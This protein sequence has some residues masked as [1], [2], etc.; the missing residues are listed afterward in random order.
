MP[1][2]YRWRQTTAPMLRRWS[3]RFDNT[4]A[5]LST[6][7]SLIAMAGLSLLPVLPAY[8]IAPAPLAGPV[9]RPTETEGGQ[10][11]LVKARR[12]K[13]TEERPSKPA[14]A[15]AP[16]A[17]LPGSQGEP[18]VTLP[19]QETVHETQT[20][21]KPADPRSAPLPPSQAP[22]APTLDTWSTAEINE[23][24]IECSRLL[25]GIAAERD[26]LPPMRSGACGTPAPIA[27]RSVGKTTLSPAA[28]VNCRLA[29]AISEWAD[30][31]LQPA[32]RKAFG[33]PVTRILTASSYACRNR[34]GLANTQISEHA[35]ANAV[36]ITGFELA[37]GRTVTVLDA[38]GSTSRDSN[39]RDASRPPKPADGKETASGSPNGST[40]AAGIPP[41]AIKPIS[42]RQGRETPD[43][44]STP[45]RSP[46]QR[47]QAG[48]E[49]AADPA[50][51]LR[52]IHKGA[53]L[54]FGTVLGPEANEAHRDHLHLDLKPRSHG[55][56][57][58]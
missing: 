30:T 45:A 16:P 42:T 8:S 38:W 23:A 22:P 10:P 32:A 11:L 48:T 43:R 26:D 20:P 25:S 39:Q 7:M 51:F 1:G 53:C 47:V 52:N 50:G 49:I 41:N 14:E 13:L 33:Q 37:D 56:L 24:R 9:A 57:C 12:V 40:G 46:S 31:T 58:E 28:T 29:V 34:Y 5:H 21:P 2:T 54:R 36:D 4:A 6:R 15:A 17:P 55:A 44:S 18:R 27:L 35:F 3:E 19:P